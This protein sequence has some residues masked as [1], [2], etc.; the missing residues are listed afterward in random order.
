MSAAL[1][2]RAAVHRK[3]TSDTELAGLIGPDRIF[4]EV[5]EAMRAPFVVLG[6]VDSRPARSTGRNSISMGRGSQTSS[7]S[8]PMRAVPATDATA[9]R[10]CA[11]G[12]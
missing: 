4:D 11:S 9:S 10:H 5:P 2:L 1:S 3:L 12:R 7:G 8:A 6:D